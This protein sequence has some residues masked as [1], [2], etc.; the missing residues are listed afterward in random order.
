MTPT[1]ADG[2]TNGAPSSSGNPPAVPSAGS[3]PTAGSVPADLD[4][5]MASA[6]DIATSVIKTTF[7]YQ[8]IAAYLAVSV[9]GTDSRQ[10]LL[11]DKVNFPI[12]NAGVPCD[13]FYIV[14]PLLLLIL[15]VYLL[16]ELYFLSQKIVEL[17]EW[18]L[19][20]GIPLT[21][22]CPRVTSLS[23]AVGLG[24]P[25]AWYV[26]A[27]VKTLYVVMNLF[28]PILLLLAMQV[29]FLPYHSLVISR[30]HRGFL[31]VDV[32]LVALFCFGQGL[33]RPRAIRLG[34]GAAGH[35]DEAVPSIRSFARWRRLARLLRDYTV[36]PAVI[37][38][39]LVA[40]LW[41]SWF[42]VTLPDGCTDDSDGWLTR[43][44][45]IMPHRILQALVHPY[46]DLAGKTLPKDGD[47]AERDLRCAQF[48][49]AT[50][51]G[52][53]FT[54]AVLTG[55][56]FDHAKLPDAKFSSGFAASLARTDSESSDEG[57]SCDAREFARTERA[58]PRYEPL[59]E[60]D[61]GLTDLRDATFDE[62]HLE[63]ADFSYARLDSAHL[64]GARLEGAKFSGAKADGADFSAAT[65]DRVIFD[66]ACLRGATLRL[67]R[68]QDSSFVHA[69][70]EVVNL[71]DAHLEGSEFG[72]AALVGSDLRGVWLQASKGLSLQAVDLRRAHLADVDLCTPP[73]EAARERSERPPAGTEVYNG[74][75]T[76]NLIHADLR[77]AEFIGKTCFETSGKDRQ[78]PLLKQL[79]PDVP[80][81]LLYRKEQLPPD[82]RKLAPDPP[83]DDD[84]Y[85]QIT[86]FLIYTK[87]D[88]APF[89]ARVA[90]RPAESS[91]F[92][93]AVAC[94]ILCERERREGSRGQDARP[95]RA[96]DPFLDDIPPDLVRALAGTGRNCSVL[97][98]TPK[99]S[100]RPH[101]FSPTCD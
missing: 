88:L 52:F 18:R 91:K 76:S 5:Q 57:Q 68:L 89:L 79:L 82:I 85:R 43:H 9:A 26:R 19:V 77:D 83:S 42:R 2:E 35:P 16:L 51:P 54:G 73:E 3:I 10:L 22:L 87:P 39:F 61:R 64:I 25:T 99:G 59:E 74:G 38:L 58:H 28:L 65:G 36:Y 100:G 11:N 23:V 24:C 101:G 27:T 13:L 55:A 47:A 48:Q 15:H 49:G 34:L 8:A 30:W 70:L 14:S 90:A 94:G 17:Q 69:H 81:T 1:T 71:R 4:A 7:A 29:K 41:L 21:Q 93:V 37:S 12:L 97:L 50:L 84:F 78:S 96:R 32:L 92:D 45:L 98:A 80:T 40:A 56:A 6:N 46:L 86:F 66:S 53:N 75:S 20:H 72:G 62:A 95:P 67:A 44:G 60:A 63:H 33:G 31:S